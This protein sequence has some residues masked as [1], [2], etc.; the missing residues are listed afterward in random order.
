M[1]AT[2]GPGTRHSPDDLPDDP[3]VTTPLGAPQVDQALVE[4]DDNTAA[5][6]AIDDDESYVPL[7][8]GDTP[9]LGHRNE[10]DYAADEP[11]EDE[12][13]SDEED[14]VDPDRWDLPT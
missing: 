12:E 8:I 3:V 5:G 6:L 1:G 10:A 4:L 11:V 2:L 14:L 7:A 13:E 9:V